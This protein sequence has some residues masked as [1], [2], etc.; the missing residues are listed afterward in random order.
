[1]PNINI[2]GISISAT[3]IQGGTDASIFD[4]IE[5]TETNTSASTNVFDVQADV[6]WSHATHADVVSQMYWVSTDTWR[7]KFCP[8]AMGVWTYN[9]VADGTGR[10]TNDSQLNGLSGSVNIA[11][12]GNARGFVVAD[13]QRFAWQIGDESS[14]NYKYFVPQM[15]RVRTGPDDFDAFPIGGTGDG[16]NTQAKRDAIFDEFIGPNSNHGFNGIHFGVQGLTWF[17]STHEL[18]DNSFSNS[19]DEPDPAT[20]VIMETTFAQCHAL[21]VYVGLW[22]FGDN[23]DNA[24]PNQWTA[25][26]Q[27]QNGNNHNR[28]MRYI[29]ARLL[30]MPGVTLGYGYDLQEWTDVTEIEARHQFYED[31]TTGIPLLLSA[32]PGTPHSGTDFSATAAWNAN[33]SVASAEAWEPRHAEHVAMLAQFSTKPCYSEDNFRDVDSPEAKDWTQTEQRQGHWLTTMAGGV[34]CQWMRLRNGTEVQRNY[35]FDNPE[36]F[37]TYFTFFDVNNRYGPNT[38]LD[39]SLSSNGHCL[40]ASDFTTYVFYSEGVS[41][42]TIDLSDAPGNMTVISVDTVA[43]YSETVEGTGF[44]ATSGHVISPGSSSDWALYV[45]VT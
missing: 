9:T 19:D 26:G 1:M 37:K 28:L 18:E 3:P 36:W 14:A 21:G 4:V 25:G 42:I 15:W 34:A 33:Q 27:G 35:V 8:P 41:S 23:T 40:R 2:P 20:F 44:S 45:T 16:Y 7:H 24:N 12:S 39:D 43:T 38:L 29:S 31:H 13:G 5:F 11:A 22:E 6:T 30:T 10:T 32:R 17:D